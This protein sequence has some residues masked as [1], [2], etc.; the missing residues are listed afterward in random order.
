MKTPLLFFLI[1]VVFAGGV[2]A[3]EGEFLYDRENLELELRMTS[4]INIKPQE[5]DY[6]VDYVRARLLFFPRETEQQ[7]I[8][9]LTTEPDA[10]VGQDEIVYEWK[11]PTT[12]RLNYLLA[13]RIT[14]NHFVRD[15]HRKIPF[16]VRVPEEFQ[17]Y[18]QPTEHIDSENPLIRAQASALAEGEDDL[19]VVLFKLASWVEQNVKYD[20]STLTADV[21]QKASWV[22]ERRVG[23]CDEMT[24][25]FIAMA[26]SLGIPARFV[27]GIS[28][29]TAPEFTENWLPHGWA[30]A[31]M[32]DIGWVAFDPTFGEFGYVD[33]T[34]IKLQESLDPAEPSSRYEWRGSP[35]IDLRTD[36]LT[37]TVDVRNLGKKG[38]A[39][40][41]LESN[42]LRE[43]VGFGSYNV[44]K[45]HV[46][47]LL[48]SYLATTLYASSSPEF[49]LEKEKV[50]VL[51]KPQE[52]KEVY[53]LGRVQGGLQEGFIYTLPVLI[54]NERNVT[55]RADF[56]VE[57]RGIILERSEAERLIVVQEEE[58]SIVK[59]ARLSC[60]L[61]KNVTTI[62][63]SISVRCVVQNTGN[64]ILRQMRLCISERCSSFDLQIGEG[65][66]VDEDMQANRVGAS[67]LVVLLTGIGVQKTLLLPY[68]V[69][70]KPMIAITHIEAPERVAFDENF[71]LSFTLEQTSFSVPQQVIVSVHGNTLRLDG[72]DGS[73]RFVIPL[74]GKDLDEGENVMAIA[75]SWQDTQ[76][77]VFETES[78]A[79]VALEELTLWQRV[80][81]FFL[82]LGRLLKGY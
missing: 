2:L 30:E 52:K 25:L 46:E 67:E 71:T 29:T 11:E 68:E 62:N 47:N 66:T 41:R 23:V 16:P 17:E 18:I 13:S 3:Q 8:S 36:E 43:R 57:E 80:Q 1:L 76:G 33:A 26:R 5:P 21:S 6:F 82:R 65:R 40:I 9:S 56:D 38:T 45:T 72:L 50:H 60:T 35:G 59:N 39:Q 44:I 79:H 61:D 14:T 58:K 24:S 53:W 55:S 64:V 78:E 51:L 54:S 15:V 22:L 42:A 73:Q 74:R 49:E 10:L 69:H 31:Y 32:P 4:A 37:F 12:Q 63:E 27:S 34:H 28:Y 70:D 20:L 48:D 77:E 19:F 7:S 81:S 75:V